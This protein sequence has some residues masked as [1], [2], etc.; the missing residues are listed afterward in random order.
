MLKNVICQA[1]DYFSIAFKNGFQETKEGTIHMPDDDPV[2]FKRLLTWVYARKMPQAKGTTNQKLLYDLYIMAEKLCMF[3][4]A[5]RTMD[6]IREC[7]ENTF[8]ISGAT[9]RNLKYAGHIFDGT[10]PSSPLRNFMLYIMVH[11]INYAASKARHAGLLISREHLMKIWDIGQDHPE[12]YE[13]LFARLLPIVPA[14]SKALLKTPDEALAD[15]RDVLFS[16]S[17]CLFHKHLA[18]EGCYL[19]EHEEE[20]AS[21]PKQP[22]SVQTDTQ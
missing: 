9:D 2:T 8:S 13:D 3:D 11:D 14:W 19:E 15:N 16:N 12:F 21:S 5:N 10:T 6:R 17:T 18:G 4:L 1:S 7:H 20:A 22:Q